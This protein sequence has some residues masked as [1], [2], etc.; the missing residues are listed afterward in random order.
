[1]RYSRYLTRENVGYFHFIPVISYEGIKAIAVRE[2]HKEL[3]SVADG[4]PIII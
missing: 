4:Q 2:V 1:M 3:H